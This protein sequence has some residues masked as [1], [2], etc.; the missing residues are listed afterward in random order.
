MNYK[1]ILNEL[2]DL[3]VPARVSLTEGNEVIV[4]MGRDYPD[5][6]SDIAWNI[7]HKSGMKFS[8]CAEASG[9]KLIESSSIHG[10]GPRKQWPYRREEEE[11]W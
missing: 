2:I 7:L 3:N 10:G 11:E 6:I 1:E 9:Y 4:E 8:L 5:D